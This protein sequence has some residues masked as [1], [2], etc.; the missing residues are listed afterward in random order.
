MTSY[1]VVCARTSLCPDGHHIVG[2]ATTPQRASCD[3]AIPPGSV[4]GPYSGPDGRQGVS[5]R[6]GRF[7]IERRFHIG[8]R[9]G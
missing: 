8:R 2:S 7:R 1:R 6:V 9:G 3:S 5:G 4:E